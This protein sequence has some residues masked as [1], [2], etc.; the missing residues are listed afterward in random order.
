[1]IA[2]VDYGAGNLQSVLNAFEAIGQKAAVVDEPAALAK[3]SAI[4]LPGVGAFGDAM[5]ALR[6]RNLLAGLREQVLERKKPYL[7][8]CLGL[9]L[10]AQESA[11]HGIHQG[12]SWID[13]TVQRIRP[14]GGQFRVP[15]IGWNTIRIEREC[16]LFNGLEDEPTFYFVHSYHL[17]V[18]EHMAQVV[19]A[20]CWH[21][22]TLTASVQHNHIYGVQFHPE[23]SQR[24]G[25]RVL[26]NFVSLI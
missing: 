12:L 25:L 19:T 11:E 21:G 15:H 1:M 17:V 24:N 20:S 4:V 8:I 22:T 3:A 2:V 7:G 6:Q 5:A 18:H 10:L 9:Q 16:P 13:G 23:K 14:E 26:E